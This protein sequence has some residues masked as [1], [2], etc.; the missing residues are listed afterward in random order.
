MPLKDLI[1]QRFGRL[2][3]TEYVGTNKT[4]HSLWKCRCDCGNEIVVAGGNLKKGNTKSCGCLH[5]EGRKPNHG[6]AN[7]KI[8][9]VWIGI[10]K[11]CLNTN[12]TDYKDYGGRGIKVCS[13]WLDD[14]QS[15][16]DYVSKLEH[17]GE[18]GYTLDRIDNSGNYEP[19]NVRWADRN[20]QARN[21][22][23]NHFLEYKGKK[24][25]LAEVAENSGIDRGA[26]NSR[27]KRG[28]IGDRLFRPVRQSKH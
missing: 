27:L 2:T 1:G 20:T 28:D 3:V 23:N 6:M 11:R 15:F 9:R 7:T 24:M 18:E 14:F 25:T 26:L 22:R 17:F 13:E 12:S 10:K 19:N 4:R 8:Y 5:N 21:K 16:Y